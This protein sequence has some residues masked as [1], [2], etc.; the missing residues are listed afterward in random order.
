MWCCP[1]CG[2]E[3]P[4][5]G[6]LKPQLK[7]GKCGECG[8]HPIERH[9]IICFAPALVNSTDAYDPSFFEMLKRI[10]ETNF[11]FVNRASLIVTLLRKYFP[12]AE[13]FLEVGCGTGSVLLALRRAVPKLRLV[14][15]ELHTLGLDIAR[16][17]LDDVL[18]L[19]MDARENFPRVRNLT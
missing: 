8:F 12:L 13:R 6:N 7:D 15:S 9:G 11:W 10:E 17:R 18:L 14:G 4:F 19:Q 1:N 3:L 5:T 16:K 2:R